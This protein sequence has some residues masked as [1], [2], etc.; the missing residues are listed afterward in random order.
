MKARKIE[1]LV[2]LT[3]INDWLAKDEL[4]L[5]AFS[6]TLV[7]DGE[8]ELE[9]R[10][11]EPTGD[12]SSEVV[13]RTFPPREGEYPYVIRTVVHYFGEEVDV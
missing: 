7:K 13:P 2:S 8:E 1:K 4:A 3:G 10:G 12:S 11:L 6:A 5:G 9:K